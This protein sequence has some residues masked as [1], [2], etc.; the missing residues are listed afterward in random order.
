MSPRRYP[1]EPLRSLEVT[2]GW[3]TASILGSLYIVGPIA[4]RV[5]IPATWL[6]YAAFALV[7]IG[8][9]GMLAH[10]W[11]Q[12]YAG[13]AW[14]AGTVG[15]GIMAVGVHPAG[16][17]VSV[18]QRHGTDSAHISA[19]RSCFAKVQRRD[20]DAF[21]DQLILHAQTEDDVLYQATIVIGEFLRG[22]LGIVNV[23]RK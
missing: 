20:I 19:T 6:D 18:E 8:I 4:L 1:Q 22:K 23:S 21:A 15:V 2:L 17:D 11:I 5:W 12:D 3:I 9:V 13:M 10:F 16:D 14:S 7:L